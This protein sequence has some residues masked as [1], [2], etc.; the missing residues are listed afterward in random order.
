MDGSVEPKRGLVYTFYSFKGGVGR[1]MALANIAALLSKWGQRVLVIDWDLEAPGIEKFFQRWISGSRRSTPG[2]V[3][4][5]GAFDRSSPRDW[6]TCLLKANLPDHPQPIHILSAGQDDLSDPKAD[7]GKN[8]Q[9]IKWEPLFDKRFGAY[10]ELLRREWTANYDFVLVDSRTGITDIGGICTI[11][12][13]DVLVCLFTTTEQSLQGVKDVMDRA[14]EAHATLPVDRRRL[15]VVPLPARDESRTEYKLAKEWRGRFATELERFYK[16]WVPKDDTAESILDLLKIPYVAFWSFGERLPVLEED[17]DNPDKLAYFYQL[18]AR[19]ML[20]RLDLQD[21]KKGTGA[22]QVSEEQK[23]EA[24]RR[25]EE[26]AVARDKAQRE[27]A[28]RMHA[29]RERETAER[30]EQY[31]AYL[32][33]RWTPSTT[34][35]ATIARL[36]VVG[37]ALLAVGALAAL[38]YGETVASLLGLPTNNARGLGFLIMLAASGV[39]S[40]VWRALGRK[41]G[42]LRRERHLFEGQ[43]GPYQ[44]PDFSGLPLFVERCERIIARGLFNEFLEKATATAFGTASPSQPVSAEPVAPPVPPHAM[45]TTPR[46]DVAD[47]YDVYVSWRRDAFTEAWLR[48]FE[49]LFTSW[50]SDLVGRAV[51]VFVDHSDPSIQ[52]LE[53]SACLLAIVTPAYF[54]SEWTRREWDTFSRFRPDAI[55]PILLRGSVQALP[56]EIRRVQL[57]DF[58]EFAFVGEGFQKTA[59]YV[60]FQTQIRRL[61]ERVA[62][63]VKTAPTAIPS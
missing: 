44:L 22:A 46:A 45:P 14:K 33:T 4:L 35:F 52:S 18:V 40:L 32:S 54:Q 63:V 49:P 31:G 37:S 15:L 36:T 27:A 57:A 43:A 62:D 25:A 3:D 8:L 39:V 34:Q 20:G 28:E 53:R 7:Y 26:A 21:V 9:Q 58:S 41:A 59:A 61:A 38:V 42:A 16:D 48:E 55:L 47:R 13:P 24:A 10:L 19:L 51:T 60:E 5:I 50:L 1:S 23:A 12:L 29:Q 2:L 11:H 30:R 17:V 6:Q 56:D